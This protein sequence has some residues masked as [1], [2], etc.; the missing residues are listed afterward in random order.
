MNNNYFYTLSPLQ[1]GSSSLSSEFTK[2]Q[3][4]TESKRH[5]CFIGQKYSAL[6]WHCAEPGAGFRKR[7]IKDSH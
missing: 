7:E 6:S 2:T 1:T 5:N 4:Q 3:Q